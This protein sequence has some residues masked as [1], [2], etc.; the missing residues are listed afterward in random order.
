MLLNVTTRKFH[1]IVVLFYPM[2]GR[3]L[4]RL[5]KVAAGKL[6]WATVHSSR[7]ILE[8]PAMTGRVRLSQCRI[9]HGI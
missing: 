2:T 1:T 7:A 5:F 6:I 9:V 4:M 8:R 3:F